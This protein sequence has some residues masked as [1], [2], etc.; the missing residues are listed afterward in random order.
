[1]ATR[2]TRPLSFVLEG[3]FFF[4]GINDEDKTTIQTAS[5]HHPHQFEP[6]NKKRGRKHE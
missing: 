4:G 2:I 1:V 5:H 3:R 6:I